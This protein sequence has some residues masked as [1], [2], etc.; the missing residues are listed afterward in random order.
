MT[1]IVTITLITFLLPVICPAQSTI[2]TFEKTY[3]GSG[4]DEGHFFSLTPDGGFIITGLTKSFGDTLGDTYLIKTDGEGTVTWSAVSGGDSLDG[5]N[6]VFQ[7][8]DGGYIV[9]NHTESYGAGDCDALVFKTDATG[10]QEWS[11]TYGDIFDDVGYE[12]IQTMDGGYAIT[13]ITETDADRSGNAFLAKY[14][15]AGQTVWIKSY[16]NWQADVAERLLQTSDGGFILAGMSTFP[17]SG[18]KDI[19]VI[20]TD[21]DGNLQW[22]KNYGGDGFEE[23]YGRA[24]T[25]DGGFVVSGFTTSFG[26]SEDAYLIKINGDGELQ[27]SRVYGGE[28]QDRAYAVAQA[29]DGGFILTGCTGSFGDTL[30]DLLLLKTDSYGNQLWLKTF[31]GAKRDEGRWVVA[32]PDGGYTAIGTTESMGNGSSDFYLVKTDDEGAITS[33][34]TL[35]GASGMVNISPNPFDSYFMIRQ[36]GTPEELNFS[37]FDVTGKLIEEQSGITS[38]EIKVLRNNISSGVYFYEV[39]DQNHLVLGKGKLIAE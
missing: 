7:T 6:S 10:N 13:G 19:L 14:D 3:G 29:S 15:N 33:D 39:T 17:A 18:P 37:L 28:K 31:G 32:R 23:A 38:Q 36:S 2:K 5:G 16:G 1:R 26:G 25:V 9:T 24:A 8:M 22:S 20:K 34:E 4:F 11:R 30:N 27:W 12:G 35:A 21:A